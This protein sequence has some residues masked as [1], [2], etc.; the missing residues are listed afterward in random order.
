MDDKQLTIADL[1]SSANE[2]AVNHGFWETPPEFGT[3]IALVHAELSEALEEVRAGRP[4]L[5]YPCRTLKRLCIREQNKDPNAHTECG[6]YLPDKK[7]NVPERS[8]TIQSDKPEGWAVELADAVI[9]IADI[10]GHYGIDLEDI[11]H[12]KMAY[13]ATR[14][15][16]HGKQF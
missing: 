1:V 15:H 3:L 9:W 10:C 11:L 5:Y 2:N 14:P 12:R 8:C 16:K 7:S 4:A 13:N 6:A